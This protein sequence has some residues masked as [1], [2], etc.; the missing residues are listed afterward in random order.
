MYVMVVNQEVD[1]ESKDGLT[2]PEKIM[3]RIK[4]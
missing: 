2:M 3:I 1:V 4:N